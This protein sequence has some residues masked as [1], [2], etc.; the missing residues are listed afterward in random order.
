[1]HNA[2]ANT[3]TASAANHLDSYSRAERMRRRFGI[4]DTATRFA[5]YVASRS[6][7]ALEHI[8]EPY[9]AVTKCN[10]ARDC[11]TPTTN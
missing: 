6:L 2:P 1:M 8:T 4:V 9:L 10:H 5:I 7:H 3:V 11:H